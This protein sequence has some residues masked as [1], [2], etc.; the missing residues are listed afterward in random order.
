[1]QKAQD[2]TDLAFN[3]IISILNPNMTEIEVAAELEYFMRKNGANALAFETIAVSSDASAL[4]HGTP[5]NIKL[6]RGFL[7]MDYGAKFDGYCSDMTRTVV[8]GKADAEIKKLY[9]TVLKAQQ[10]AID[11]LREGCDAGEA[12]KIARD[13]IDSVPEYKGAFGHSLGHSVGLFIHESPRVS[14]KSFGEK[15]KKGNVVTVEPG[16]YLFVK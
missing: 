15:L 2:I 10:D 14:F 4:P 9:S 1:M 3:H 8:I 7:T 12:D 16:I 11:Y 5:R 13:I 6:N